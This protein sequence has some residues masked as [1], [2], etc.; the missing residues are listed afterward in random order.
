MS[1]FVPKTKPSTTKGISAAEVEAKHIGK[2]YGSFIVIGPAERRL[3]RAWAIKC[4]CTTCGR[5]LLWPVSSLENHGDCNCAHTLQIRERRQKMNQ[6]H[7][8]EEI[9][10][11]W[12]RG[13][14]A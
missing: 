10:H 14:K 5:E 1:D 12:V 11:Q 7:P 6:R 3:K 13:K 8:L 9:I 4:R 2:T